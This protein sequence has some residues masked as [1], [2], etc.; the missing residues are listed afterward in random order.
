MDAKYWASFVVTPADE[1]IFVGVYR[2]K[3]VGISEQDIPRPHMGG[4]D[5]AG[6]CDIYELELQSELSDLIGKLIIEWG[7]GKLAWVQYAHRK[8]KDVVELRAA[9]KEPEFPGFLNF[10]GHL[11]ELQTLP[12]GWITALSS[13][14][15]VYLL[16]CPKTREQY[17][18]S[19]SGEGGFWQRWTDYARNGHGGDIALKSRDPSGYQVSILEV[20][21]TAAA[22]EDIIAME[23]RWKR[24]LQSR[25][26]GLNRN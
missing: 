2:S 20:A 16:T 15:G 5:P 23:T 19:A 13:T 22:G 9:F 6:S 1:T 24:K 14:K 10:F 17:V 26:M 12:R 4:I 21:G 18:G 7:P 8:N 25:E 3:Y 11:S